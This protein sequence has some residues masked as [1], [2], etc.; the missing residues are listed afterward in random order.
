M[1]RT[2][3]TFLSSLLLLF[4]LRGAAQVPDREQGAEPAGSDV[5]SA[6]EPDSEPDSDFGVAAEVAAPAAS[7]NPLDA[8]ASGTRLP[9]RSG[10]EPQDVLVNAPGAQVVQTGG[11]GAFSS[12]ALRG[13]ELGHTTL[14]LGDLPL[15]GPD[16]GAVDLSLM[17]MNAFEALE[18]YRGGAPAWLNSGAM[19]GVVR[20]V[21]RRGGR[22]VGLLARGG[23]FS[24]WRFQGYAAA[25]SDTVS[26]VGAAGLDGSRG[27][28]PYAF[29]NATV[30]ESEDDRTARRQN[31]DTLG[32]HAFAHLRWQPTGRDRL[33]LVVL[34]TS[35]QGGAPGP[36]ANV[37]HHARRNDARWYGSL[38]YNRQ[39]DRADVQVLAGGGY[40]RHRFSDPRG[41]I[42]FDRQATDDRFMA[43]H[44]RVATRL[45]LAHFLELTGVGGA[46]WDGYRPH[47]A[48]GTTGPPGSRATLSG[49]LEARLHGQIASMP[50]ELRPSVRLEHTTT[51]VGQ[52]R[53]LWVPTFRVGAA[54][55][56]KPWATIAASVARGVRL[57]NMLE[58]FGN[59]GALLPSHDLQPERGTAIDLGVVFRHRHVVAEARIFHTALTDL[60]RYRPTSQ[61]TAKAENVVSAQ[62][63]GVEA[64]G[65]LQIIRHLAIDAAGTWMHTRAPHGVTLNWRP[66]LQ[67]QL[68]PEVSTGPRGNIRNFAVFAAWNFRSSFFQDP[69]NLIELPGRHWL[70]LGAR[71]ELPSGFSLAVDARDLLDQRGQDFLGFPLPGRR[72]AATLRYEKDL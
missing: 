27:D 63:F 58:L 11:Q 41:E 23:S 72:F 21:P 66:W 54:W 16:T 18:V 35:R 46:R 28:F 15:S 36:G 48:V 47:D 44:L 70:A 69:A 50:V 49:T 1:A 9:I 10:E 29:D 3:G 45:R 19:G 51:E 5:P 55:S 22:R 17:P 6:P 26:F 30:F 59:R 68:R 57:P 52:R 60:I 20:L 14:Y 25:A 64:G 71:V 7:T 32:G 37:A 56:V 67:T 39:T 65:R 34:G 24:S 40:Q 33:A 53:S 2:L 61:Y 12:V 4:T 62:V 42:G 31:A 43:A 8:T 13:A 38:S